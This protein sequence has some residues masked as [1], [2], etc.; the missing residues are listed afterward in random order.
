[1]YSSHFN[2]QILPNMCLG[3]SSGSV[4]KIGFKG[5]AAARVVSARDGRKRFC[6][7]PHVN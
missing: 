4:K 2:L 6:Y 3:D 7:D 5:E 1:M